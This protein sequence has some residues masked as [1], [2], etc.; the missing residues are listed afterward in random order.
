MFKPTAKKLVENAVRKLW[1]RDTKF[2]VTGTRDEQ[3]GSYITMCF[4]DDKYIAT[5]ESRDW[6]MSYKKLKTLV[7]EYHKHTTVHSAPKLI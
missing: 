3:S 7:E 2:N 4:I 6:R 1:G 5:A